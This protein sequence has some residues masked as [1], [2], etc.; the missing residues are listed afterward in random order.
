M[1]CKSVKVNLLAVGKLEKCCFHPLNPHVSHSVS[2]PVLGAPTCSLFASRAIVPVLQHFIGLR[3]FSSLCSA[4]ADARNPLGPGPLH[5]GPAH[6]PARCFP[7]GPPPTAS[8]GPGDV[9]VHLAGE[10]NPLMLA[11]QTPEGERKR[12][13]VQP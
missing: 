2:C 3:L 9:G 13:L 7:A 10:E 5:C 6:P 8:V 1:G 11:L 4:V 12:D